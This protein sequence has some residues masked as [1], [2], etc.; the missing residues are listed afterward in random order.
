MS[1]VTAQQQSPKYDQLRNLSLL[2]AIMIVIFEHLPVY[3]AAI[4]V[5]SMPIARR[6]CDVIM[7]D[8]F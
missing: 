8:I 3:D 4:A 6:A 2:C 5:S 7:V 1:L